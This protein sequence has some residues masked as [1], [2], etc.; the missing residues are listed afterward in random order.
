MMLEIAVSTASAGPVPAGVP[1][2]DLRLRSTDGEIVSLRDLR[3]KAV[4]LA[5]YPNDWS[6]V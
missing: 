3:G 1:A 6:P 2:P 4:I 5:F